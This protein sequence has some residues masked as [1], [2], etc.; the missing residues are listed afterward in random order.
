MHRRTHTPDP[1][2]TPDHALPRDPEVAVYFGDDSLRVYQLR[3]WLPVFE[4][5]DH[6]HP[7]RVI[8]RERTTYDIVRSITQLPVT[9]YP[10]FGELTEAYRISP[11]KVVV[12]VNNSARN[13]QSLV[14]RSVTHV[15]VNHGESDKI[16]MVSNQVKAYDQVFVA[17]EAA[18]NRHRATLL[19]FD[20]RR[21]VPVGRPQLDLRPTPV[22]APS[23]QAT[24]LYAPTW[25]GEEPS[26][27][28][29]SVDVMGPQ[30]IRAVL[31]VPEVRVVYKPHPRVATSTT[32]A[33]ASAHTAIL[34]LLTETNRRDPGA[35][36]VVDTTSDI[37]AIFPTCDIMITDVS[38]V[39]LDFLYLHGDR[40]LLITDRYT[41]RARLA[42]NAPVSRC[43]DVISPGILGDLPALLDARLTDDVHA[44]ARA[45]TRRYYFG[46]REVGESTRDFI[47]SI[48]VA[49]QLRD[50]RAGARDLR[51]RESAVPLPV[52]VE[53]DHRLTGVEMKART[54]R[55]RV[56]VRRGHPRGWAGQQV[57][58]VVPQATDAA[59]ERPQHHATAAGQPGWRLR[60]RCQSDGRRRLPTRLDHGRLPGRPLCVQRAVRPDEYRQES[61]QSVAHLW[62]RRDAVA[63]R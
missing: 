44:P 22:L 52:Y 58:H 11:H 17:G 32:P 19:G 12:Y 14:A 3:Q 9:L 37:L 25:E 31:A 6:K 46:N 4:L 1:C 33:M 36:H 21:L 26:N 24:I 40:P 10:T 2:A 59:V 34:N 18:I 43:A 8:L 15:H 47:E 61:P 16:C 54:R 23:T 51:L 50:Q 63:Q 48:G 57:G 45:A 62:A 41:D 28:Y 39:G 5:L 53:P 27:N 56:P 60:R 13:F 55:S 49:I 35:G 29:T 42:T 7:V 20:E 38:S 30:I